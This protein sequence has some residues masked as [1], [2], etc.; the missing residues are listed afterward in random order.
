VAPEISCR[1]AGPVRQAVWK[2]RGVCST[3]PAPAKIVARDKKGM[4]PSQR[5]KDVT[6]HS[7]LWQP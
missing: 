4:S 6:A 1:C 7:S 5:W 3:L 2:P